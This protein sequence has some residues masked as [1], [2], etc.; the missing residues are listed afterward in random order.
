METALTSSLY[1]GLAYVFTVV[2]LIIPFLITS[3][4]LLALGSTLVVAVLIIFFFN[5]YV[6]V[7]KDYSFKKRFT[8]MAVLSI[9]VALISFIIGYL[10][11]V[12]LG[13][14]I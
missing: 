8:E 10:I 3:N 4:Y 2:A 5:Y 6:S 14:E 9:G 11:R 13:V 7:A 1:T 12:T